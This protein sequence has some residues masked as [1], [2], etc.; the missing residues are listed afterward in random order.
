M[1]KM[2]ITPRELFNM[3]WWDRYC[4]LTGTSPY[5]CN[6]GQMRSDEQLEVPDAMFGQ[7]LSYYSAK[8]R[9]N[10]EN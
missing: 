5:A 9:K 3:C 2:T 7:V 6:E 8:N 10:Y 1:P 4:D